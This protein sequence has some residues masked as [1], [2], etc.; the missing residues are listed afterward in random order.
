MATPFDFV[1]SI[2]F[3]KREDMFEDPQA[4][5]EYTPFIVNRALSYFPDCVL[6]A[7]EMNMYRDTPI[8][9][10]Y[11]YLK[12]SI[13]KKKRYSK[14]LKKQQLHDDVHQV[15]IF[16]KYSLSKALEIMPLLSQDEIEFIKQEINEGGKNGIKE[17]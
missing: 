10:Q 2:T 14:W 5:K 11:S 17:K 4:E 6:Y 13:Q 3:E 12:N 7:N 1:K 8:K 15:S 9:S 16:Y